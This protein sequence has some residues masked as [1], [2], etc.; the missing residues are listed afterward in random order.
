M[1]NRSLHGDV[2]ALQW[3]VPAAT[4][5]PPAPA[6]ARRRLVNPAMCAEVPLTGLSLWCGNRPRG[7]SLRACECGLRSY[8]PGFDGKRP[9]RRP[10]SR[11]ARCLPWDRCRAT[12]HPMPSP[13]ASDDDRGPAFPDHRAVIREDAERFRRLPPRQRWQEL[14]AL[15]AWANRLAASTPQGRR[16]RELESEAEARWQAIQRELFARHGGAD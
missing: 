2:E 15:R 11:E 16:T 10:F 3:S 6:E 13:P 4:D 8:R 12:L 7:A 1:K 9:A 14:F 5:S